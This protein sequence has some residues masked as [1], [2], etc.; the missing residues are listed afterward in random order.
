MAVVHA[1]L[2][3]RSMGLGNTT[4]DAPMKRLLAL[5]ALCATLLPGLAWSQSAP[6]LTPETRKE[7]S[8]FF[9]PLAGANMPA[10]DQTTLTDEDLLH[11]ALWRCVLHPLPGLKRTRGGQDIII[12]SAVI[13][14]IT[15]SVFGRAM[16]KHDKAQYVESLASGEAFV[17]AQADSLRQ[18]DGDTFLAAGTI[19]YT[20]AGEAIDPHATRA[21]WKRAGADVRVWGTFSGVLK[22]TPEPAAHWVLL[23]YAVKEAS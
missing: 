2:P 10:F 1:A 5:L 8:N 7:L 9:S 14:D 15:R 17:F 4:E 16:A 3:T 21:Q 23:Q 19:Y 18:G 12:P 6:T 20:A 22:R 11:F 13:D